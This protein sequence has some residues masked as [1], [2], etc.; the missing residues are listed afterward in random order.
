MATNVTESCRDIKA[1]NPLCQVLLNLA[2]DEIKKKGVNPLI[3]E[4]YRS[5]ERQNYLY[6]QGR[7]R[8]GSVVTWTLNSIHTKKN[9]VDVIPQRKINGKMVAI[10][11]A[12]DPQTQIII[13]TMEKYGFEAGY[14]W[15]SSPDSPHFQIKDVSVNGN[16]YLKENTNYYITRMIQS[17]LNKKLGIH[18]VVDGKWGSLTTAAINDFRVKNKWSKNGKLGVKALTTLMK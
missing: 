3:V 9:A 12:N 4:T 8:A 18:L 11:N 5:Q 7:T 2:L 17:A 10:W 15:L 13:K 6:A 16:E 1:L 14:N